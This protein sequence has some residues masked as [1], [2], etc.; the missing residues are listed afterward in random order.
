MYTGTI[1]NYRAKRYFKKIYPKTLKM[2]LWKYVEVYWVIHVSDF[3]IGLFGN[4]H[5]DLYAV[6]GSNS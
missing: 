6:E 2:A 1:C 4:G 3:G 5:S